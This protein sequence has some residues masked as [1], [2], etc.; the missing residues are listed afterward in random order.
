MINLKNISTFLAIIVMAGSVSA[1]PVTQLT[2]SGT[3]V[4]GSYYAF[5]SYYIAKN[6]T[7]DGGSNSN[8]SEHNLYRLETYFIDVDSNCQGI[9]ADWESYK[10]ATQTANW[11]GGGLA[12]WEYAVIHYGNGLNIG[13]PNGLGGFVTAY[14]LNGNDSFQFP[15]ESFSSIDLYSCNGDH[16]V[17]DNGSSLALLGI[18]LTS[19]AALSQGRWLAKA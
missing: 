2:P 14:A 1:V 18:A 11:L 19:I 15:S 5:L 6:G 3:T 13:A 4:Y 9:V 16:R 12:G 7:G 10:P 8:N 17:P